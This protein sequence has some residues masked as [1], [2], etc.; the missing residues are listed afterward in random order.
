MI[1]YGSGWSAVHCR[2]APWYSSAAEDVGLPQAD[3]VAEA[4]LNTGT[5]LLDDDL[6]K[7][8]NSL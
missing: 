4:E 8:V 2:R 3:D 1:P 5:M 7:T 6:P